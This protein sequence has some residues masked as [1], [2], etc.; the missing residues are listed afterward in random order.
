MHFFVAPI[1]VIPGINSSPAPQNNSLRLFLKE[2]V[3]V[4]SPVISHVTA[5]LQQLLSLGRI[6]IWRGMAKGELPGKCG[7]QKNPIP[8]SLD[9][10]RRSKGYKLERK[11]SKYLYLQMI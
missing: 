7:N 2:I 6:W 1:I 10:K 3:L 5:L 11:K 9:N 4:V 8:G